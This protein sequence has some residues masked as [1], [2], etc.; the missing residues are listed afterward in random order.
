ML[1]QIKTVHGWEVWGQLDK[2]IPDDHYLYMTGRAIAGRPAMVL[3]DMMNVD[4][5]LTFRISDG[6]KIVHVERTWQV[7]G[8][9]VTN[10]GNFELTMVQP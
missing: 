2:I 4:K 6:D 8:I 7:S 5:E 9:E 3:K 10:A 1:L